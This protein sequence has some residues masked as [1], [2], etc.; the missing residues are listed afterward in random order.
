M[1]NLMK[2]TKRWRN[3]NSTIMHMNK[4]LKVMVKNSELFQNSTVQVLGHRVDKMLRDVTR[5]NEEIKNQFV[6]LHDE[7]DLEIPGSL[8][9]KEVP[10]SPN[11][12]RIKYRKETEEEFMRD[13]KLAS[14]EEAFLRA[15]RECPVCYEICTA[16]EMVFNPCS[17]YICNRCH[18]MLRERKCPL[19]MAPTPQCIRYD[20]RGENVC[21]TVVGNTMEEPKKMQ[22]GRDVFV[23]YRQSANQIIVERIATSPIVISDTEDYYQTDDSISRDT[24]WI[25]RQRRRE[26][27]EDRSSPPR[28]EN[29]LDD[30]P[31][32]D[33]EFMQ[34]LNSLPNDLP[35]REDDDTSSVN[36]VLNS[37]HSDDERITQS[38]TRLR[39]RINRR[40]HRMRSRRQHNRFRRNDSPMPSATRTSARQERYR[41]AAERSRLARPRGRSNRN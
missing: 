34:V 40:V 32:V 4:T 28:Y 13:V 22:I 25:E 29:L 18:A 8:V 19:C 30:E 24:E 38:I 5:L 33:E 20:K 9:K 10:E 2:V 6:Q 17:H 26:F 31:Q 37:D 7:R 41:T 11:H 27:D 21:Y 35:V 1:N 23:E 12:Y 14:A 3:I 16:L 39:E 15:E 36:A